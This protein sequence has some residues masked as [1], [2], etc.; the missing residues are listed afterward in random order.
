MRGNNYNWT[1]FLIGLALLAVWFVGYDFLYSVKEPVKEV[2]V[3]ELVSNNTPTKKKVAEILETLDTMVVEAEAEEEAEQMLNI[4]DRIVMACEK[5]DIPWEIPL[6]IARLET[7]WFTSNAYVNKNN[8]GG[9]SRNE[10]PISFDTIE[11]GVEAFISNLAENYFAI[12]LDTPEEIGK[13][14]C[15]VNPEWASLV[16]DL[17]EYEYMGG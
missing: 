4:E 3:P 14:Y 1:G 12:G 9:L 2:E 8:P 10:V 16:R 7:G 13:K 11:E 6:A 5:Y 15:P 17:M